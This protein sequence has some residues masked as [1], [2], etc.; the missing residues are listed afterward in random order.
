MFQRSV[1]LFGLVFM[2][3]LSGCSVVNG[4]GDVV[5]AERNIDAF[6]TVQLS[7]DGDLT[8]K[9]GESTFLT[10]KGEDNII[11]RVETFV[12]G[13]KLIIRNREQGVMTIL[14]NTQPIEI[15]VST[16]NIEEIDVSGSGN[17]YAETLTTDDM[18][19]SISGSGDVELAL[20]EGE[21]V[22]ISI[23][24][25][26]NFKTDAISASSLDVQ[27]TGSG[28]AALAGKV[29]ETVLDVTGSGTI[30]SGDLSSNTARIRVTGSGQVT[31]WV[32]ESVDVDISGSGDL[33]YYGSPQ[34]TQDISGSGNISSLGAK[35]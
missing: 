33:E 16:P 18:D 4:S 12:R 1:V 9:Q 26:G 13:D 32:K 10:I 24:G 8:I 5:T 31:A 23:S 19:V 3:I 7:I 6:D 17:V 22:D 20:L 14:R 25:S 27:V 21:K 34:I 35:E 30:D 29:N 15:S 28:D 2:L 11:E